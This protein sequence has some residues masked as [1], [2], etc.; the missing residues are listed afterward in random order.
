MY[1]Y[2]LMIKGR[3]TR[4][5]QGAGLACALEREGPGGS[6]LRYPPSLPG[7]HTL[8]SSGVTRVL[9]VAP[10]QPEPSGP[11]VPG[12]SHMRREWGLGCTRG[13]LV[14]AAAWGDG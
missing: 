9:V 11:R 2:I 1:F 6:G 13:G 8:V 14:R 5:P 10:S 3:R 4:E 12:S 7:C